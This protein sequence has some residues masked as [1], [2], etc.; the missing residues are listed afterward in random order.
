METP[1]RRISRRRMA[2]RRWAS[3]WYRSRS[4]SGS[5]QHLRR[6][7]SPEILHPASGA[8]RL[9]PLGGDSVRPGEEF[10]P[11]LRDREG[12]LQAP[13]KAGGELAAG[14]VELAEAFEVAAQVVV[15]AC[16]AAFGEDRNAARYG[17]RETGQPVVAEG[18][19]VRLQVGGEDRVRRRTEV[20]EIAGLLETPG[21]SAAAGAYVRLNRRTRPGQIEEEA[22]GA[23]G[24][25]QRR[26]V[27]DAVAEVVLEVA[28]GV[29]GAPFVDGAREHQIEPVAQGQQ[30]V[31]PER[32][33][34][35]VVDG[36]G[37]V[38][39]LVA[40]VVGVS[41]WLKGAQV[42]AELAFPL[43]VAAVAVALGERRRRQHEK[44]REGDHHSRLCGSPFGNHC[45][46][47][48]VTPFAA[49][50]E[51]PRC[52]ARPKGRD[53]RGKPFVSTIAARG[54]AMEIGRASC[55]ER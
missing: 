18:D 49:L 36:A 44:P 53:E 10:P 37:E 45:S 3:R 54:P 4:T 15:D 41:V 52:Q 20:D 13:G 21:I 14:E 16:P 38:G 39:L 47:S 12:T 6:R 8:A 31:E 25:A 23:R 55:R 32:G 2:A 26:V 51:Q 29:G 7:L 46:L 35:E 9:C 42:N 24:D 30:V 19:A 33:V 11:G 22:H 43:G 5:I 40:P 17:R 28:V 48:Y 1:C 34:L 27:A 50:H